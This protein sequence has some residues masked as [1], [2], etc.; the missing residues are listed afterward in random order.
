MFSFKKFAKLEYHKRLNPK[1]WTHDSLKPEVRQHL[2][3]I[4]KA[5]IEFIKVIPQEA[6]TDIRLL[7]GS[8]NYNYT[9]LSDIDVHIMVDPD[10]IT[11]NPDDFHNVIMF[12]KSVWAQNH[13]GITVSGMPV[14][15]YGQLLTEQMPV[16]QGAYSLMTNE[17][18]QKPEYLAIKYDS[19]DLHHAVRNYKEAIDAAIA[20]ND[21]EVAKVLKDEIVS[22]R[23]VG[24]A[25]GGEFDDLPTTFKALRN[26]GYL[27]TLSDWI[28]GIEDKELSYN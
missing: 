15:L 16:G 17:W 21:I 26:A 27:Q 1:L 23:G 2:L 10:K 4:A 8:C 12:G 20:S 5:W 11:M 18:L 3:T 14:E 9:P 22:N 19:K 24:L 28:R 7:G 13:S 6:I 25:R